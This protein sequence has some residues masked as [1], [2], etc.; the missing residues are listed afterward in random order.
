M[1]AAS[2]KA[3]D[4]FGAALKAREKIVK[5][6]RNGNLSA[7]A[8]REWTQANENLQKIAIRAGLVYANEYRKGLVNNSEMNSTLLA[9]KWNNGNKNPLKSRLKL[10]LKANS[11]AYNAA[12]GAFQQAPTNHKAAMNLVNKAAAYMAVLRLNGKPDNAQTVNANTNVRNARTLIGTAVNA[13]A[14]KN[15]ALQAARQNS[16]DKNRLFAEASANANRK[17]E[18]LEAAIAAGANT[19]R[20]RNAARAATAAANA[21]REA[22]EEAARAA[23]AK[24]GAMTTLR[25]QK[26]NKALQAY[27]NIKNAPTNTQ[28]SILAKRNAAYKLWSVQKFK[29]NKTPNQLKIINN[30]KLYINRNNVKNIGGSANAALGRAAA[31]MAAATTANQRAE[32][33]NAARTAAERAAAA[34]NAARREANAA[35]AQANL[36]RETAERAAAAATNAASRAAA[37]KNR[38]AAEAARQAANASAAVA[39]AQA[40]AAQAA[41][42]AAAA[43][44]AGQANAAGKIQA[45]QTAAAA[46]VKAAENAAARNVAAAASNAA[47]ASRAANAAR[48]EAAEAK[49]QANANRNSAAAQIALAV[50]NAEK[51]TTEA[52]AARA[53]ANAALEKARQNAARA[54]ASNAEKAAVMAAA[55][56]ARAAYNAE[57]AAAKSAAANAAAAAANA[58]RNAQEARGTAAEAEAK[59]AEALAKAAANSA[60]AQEA[61]TRAEAAE[62]NAERSR[63][64]KGASVAAL[65]ALTAAHEA[66]KEAAKAA[67]A[68][69]ADFQ[70]A[71]NAALAT[72]AN[73]NKA[74]AAVQAQRNELIK[75]TNEL[76]R[77]A[78]NA[79]TLST[80]GP[81]INANLQAALKRLQQ[82]EK[83]ASKGIINNNA[84]ARMAGANASAR[85]R[86]S[87]LLNVAA[88]VEYYNAL[89]NIKPHTTNFNNN[90]NTPWNKLSRK[91]PGLQNI[92]A[93]EN[94]PEQVL[95]R[96]LTNTTLTNANKVIVKAELNRREYQKAFDAEYKQYMNVEKR[97]KF[98]SLGAIKKRIANALAKLGNNE[99]RR[100]KY[101]ALAVKFNKN[102]MLVKHVT[103]LGA[104]GKL[105]NVPKLQN[106][107]KR[108]R[109]WGWSYDDIEKLRP[110]YNQY[111]NANT[112]TIKAGVE[113]TNNRI[114]KVK[115]LKLAGELAPYPNLIRAY[116][117]G[118]TGGWQ[119]KQREYFNKQYIRFF[120]DNGKLK[121][122]SFAK[123]GFTKLV[124]PVP[125]RNQ[126]GGRGSGAVYGKKTPSGKEVEHYI[127]KNGTPNKLWPITNAIINQNGS[128]YYKIS[129]LSWGNR[130]APAGKL[131]LN[132]T[133]RG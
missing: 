79:G 56:N 96:L 47:A 81:K 103:N 128:R 9:A 71:R 101:N 40:A 105:A 86:A 88:N 1:S 90:E 70:R 91:V 50:A 49:R 94:A 19:V 77:K 83:N 25:N 34:A 123:N 52:A 3:N 75:Q 106:I 69:A 4:N 114:E 59:K 65:S 104:A 111:I 29:N 28:A 14:A 63:R 39:A 7:E 11:N 17:R 62:A 98:N 5:R 53:A 131:S 99:A 12:K 93:I 26:F 92:N 18:A 44:E 108:T 35:K 45:A 66:V 82:A 133:A 27:I 73:K 132:P 84:L 85:T 51:K 102:A 117:Q 16:V 109:N 37:E 8:Q 55:A 107:Y 120:N 2:K 30:A 24:M 22:A 33:A 121:E 72:V 60:A 127:L 87:N 64:E 113:T 58:A 67:N 21:A 46:A 68:R 61:L 129:G 15:A 32:A 36:N 13:L 97:A 10:S 6:I 41:T 43:V 112:G 48:A 118:S 116:N 122:F 95:K 80:N 130:S 23:A 115:Q 54:N 89:E 100:A 38:I 74:L 119:P 42:N 78:R 20:E 126:K 76:K 110:L 31:A 57:I 124:A 125:W